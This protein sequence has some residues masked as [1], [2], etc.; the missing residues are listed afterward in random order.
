V[1]GCW[2]AAGLSVT[3][4]GRPSFASDIGAQGLTLSDYSGWDAS[5]SPAKIDYQCGPE[6]LAGADIIALCV[7]SGATAEAAKQIAQHARAGA[8]VLSLQNGISNVDVLEHELGSRFEV[9][10]GMVPYNVAYWA[11]AIQGAY[12]FFDDCPETR[13][14]TKRMVRQPG[15][16][17]IF[18]YAG[19]PGKLINPNAVSALS[20]ER[21]EELRERNYRRPAASMSE[22]L[23]AKQGDRATKVGAVGP[24]CFLGDQR[25]RLALQQ[26]LLKNGRLMPRRARWLTTCRMTQDRG[27]LYKWRTGAPC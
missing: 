14:L 24:N 12:L 22:G 21:F 9:V 8:I 7:K 18:R 1:G 25:P 17:T 27:R 15:A 3:F 6:G 2:Q 4:I 16:Q 23:R 10:R 20:G 11:K 13:E 19:L 5:I 26:C